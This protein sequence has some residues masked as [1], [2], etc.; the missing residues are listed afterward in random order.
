MPFIVLSFIAGILTVLAPCSFSLLPIIIGGTVSGKNKNRA[1]IIT[2]S[3]ALSIILFTLLLKVSTLLTNLDPNFLNYFSGGAIIIFGITSLFPQIWDFISIKLNLSAKSDELLIESQK[4]QGILGSVL[5]GTALGPVFSSC[6]P[7]YA[8]IIATVLRSSLVEGILNILAY[9]AGLSLVMFLIAYFGQNFIKRFR[10][11]VN[12]YGWFK[13]ILGI[14]F[15]IIGI[16]I[17]TGYD[18]RIIASIP[19]NSFLNTSKIERDLLNKTNTKSDTY[20]TTKD[21]QILNVA[22]P[23]QTPEIVGIDKWINS[24][25]QTI[26]GLKGKV[27]L[28]DFWTY[29][30]INCQRTLPYLTTWYNTYKDKGFVVLGIHAPEFS[31][32]K[33]T[34]NVEKA[35]KEF[36]I[37]YPVGLDNDFKTWN[38]YNNQAWPGEY[39]IDKEGKIRRTHFGE[40]NYAE[41]EKAIRTLLEENGSKLDSSLATDKVTNTGLT[42][43]D[44]TPETYLGFSRSAK[45][46]NNNELT[47][48]QAYNKPYTYKKVEALASDYWSLEGDWIVEN[49]NIISNS[50]EAKFRFKYNAKE[51]YLVMGSDSPAD[52][53]FTG[54]NPGS[55]V[56]N[57]I[58]KV[59][60]YKLYK[61][62]KGDKFLKDGEFELAVPKGTKLNVFTFGS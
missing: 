53:K 32:E 34:E 56:T 19:E 33:K 26:K 27:V 8:V 31:F 38:N 57:G 4:K 16:A 3:L 6:S 44:Q 39:L 15:I 5:V 23:T 37:K 13:K 62:V 7:T 22:K 41:S 18:K 1:L 50:N 52:I 42:S 25:P 20:A 51:V 49:E 30:C 55:D 45:F 24:D 43:S 28:I 9:V 60:D 46:A 29:S 48:N 54:Q 17:L 36:N 35:V 10:W 11:A 12:P 59:S 14:V 58:I 47:V 21:S 2:L 40:G 61:L